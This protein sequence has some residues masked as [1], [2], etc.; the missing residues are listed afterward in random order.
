MKI[1][2]THVGTA[3][4]VL[5]IDGLRIITDPVLGGPC[6][7]HFGWGMRSRH[8]RGP[9]VDPASI[10]RP[11]VVLLSHDQHDDNLDAEGRVL[12]AR[13]GTVLTTRRAAA[14]LGDGAIG[15][16]P[17]EQHV[18]THRGS[19]LRITATPARHGPP[20]SLPFVGPVVGFVLE[21]AGQAHGALY[22]S[23]DTVYF[24]GIDEI[25]R[26]FR[27]GTAVLHLGGAHFGPLR[28]TMD[29]REGVRA[30][31]TLGARTVVPVHYAD[32]S[33]FGDREE[34]I[35]R[36]FLE[37]GLAERLRRLSPGARCAVE[38]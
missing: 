15:L 3:M 10:R 26:S 20:L 13:A 23:G 29:A 12:L 35:E 36:A 7:C 33:H 30:A 37:R 24:G 11:D 16:R 18:V 17:F 19:A 21:W 34:N 27:I 4:L 9:H 25:A 38:V 32:W 6:S 28:F 31:R 14:R 1:A 8:L 2:M 5:E 22:I